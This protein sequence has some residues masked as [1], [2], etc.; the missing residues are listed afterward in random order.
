[1]GRAAIAALPPDLAVDARGAAA[2]HH[3]ARRAWLFWDRDVLT[4]PRDRSVAALRAQ[5]PTRVP[6]V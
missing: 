3:Q 2:I 6:T 4:T 5:H 1:M